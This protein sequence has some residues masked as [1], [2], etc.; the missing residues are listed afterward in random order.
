L[1]QAFW[2]DSTS[3]R[4]LFTIDQDLAAKARAAG[5]PRCGAKL[6]SATYPRK[7]RGVPEHSKHYY[8]RRFSFTCRRCEIEAPQHRTTPPSARF[9]GRKVY[10]AMIVTLISA[11]RNGLTDGRLERLAETLR[12]DRRTVEHWR[13][14][15]LETFTATP[16]WRAK[17]SLFMPPV[18]PDHLPASLLGRFE[19][20]PVDDPRACPRGGGELIAFLR[21]LE[22]I[23]G[24]ASAQ[25]F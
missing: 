4:F 12:I 11:M 20:S 13:A 19:P 1:Y 8:E 5:C 9:L 6:H 17:S 10:L 7:P 15:W 16:F 14:W 18:A 22:P 25:A 21:F 24:G 2:A 3:H 23:T